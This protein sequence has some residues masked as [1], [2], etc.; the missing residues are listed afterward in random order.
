MDLPAVTHCELHT[1]FYPPQLR[2]GLVRS[3]LV[4]SGLVRECMVGF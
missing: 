3:G 1:R 4:R 2:S